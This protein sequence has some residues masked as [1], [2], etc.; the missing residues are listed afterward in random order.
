MALLDLVFLS[1]AFVVDELWFEFFVEL[2]EL[3]DL[4]LLLEEDDAHHP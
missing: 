2:L 3:D 4:E 1:V